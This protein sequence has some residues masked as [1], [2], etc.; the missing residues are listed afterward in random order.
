MKSEAF[1]H[2]ES[3][4]RGVRRGTEGLRVST[5]TM[6]PRRQERQEPVRAPAT[7]H[8]PP[9]LRPFSQLA[10]FTAFDRD[11]ARIVS[12]EGRLGLLG[13]VRRGRALLHA[14]QRTTSTVA[15]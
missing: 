15:R 3:V 7:V 9:N 10:S 13:C 8:G 14:D 11:C 4:P 6:R 2:D 1:P 12:T 5:R